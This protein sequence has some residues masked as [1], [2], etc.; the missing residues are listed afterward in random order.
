[1]RTT[2]RIVMATALMV[3]TMSTWVATAAADIRDW[4]AIID[5]GACTVQHSG[6]PVEVIDVATGDVLAWLEPGGEDSYQNDG[7][8]TI[9]VRVYL[10]RDNF[11][12]RTVTFDCNEEPPPPTE[13][14]TTTTT[15]PPPPEDTTTTTTTTPPTEPPPPIEPPQEPTTTTTMPP[16]V[17]STTLVP[18]TPVPVSPRTPFPELGPPKSFDPEPQ[19]ETRDRCESTDDGKSWNVTYVDGVETSRVQVLACTGGSPFDNISWPRAAGV[20]GAL[21]TLIFSAQMW[22]T[23]PKGQ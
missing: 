19:P 12:S 23:R 5:E 7:P 21:G 4:S 13:P 6:A 22:A 3:M 8:V 11:E 2:A 16:P 20:L 17:T 15:E 1:M 14:P 10:Q 9:E 18:H